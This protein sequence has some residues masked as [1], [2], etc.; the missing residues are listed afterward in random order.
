[1]RDPNVTVFA[2]ILNV[3]KKKHGKSGVGYAVR[4]ELANKQGQLQDFILS[5]NHVEPKKGQFWKFQDDTSDNEGHP[6]AFF[7][8][9][10]E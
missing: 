5:P 6:V 2:T 1:M 9:D 10:K 4:V 8:S 3:T 7:V